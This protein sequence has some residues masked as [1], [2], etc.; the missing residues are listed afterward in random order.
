MAHP[1]QSFIDNLVIKQDIQR[2]EFMDIKINDE[3]IPKD[4]YTGEPWVYDDKITKIFED[5]T[6]NS[7]TNILK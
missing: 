2:K 6:T 1:E 5:I 3:F 7:T 4:P